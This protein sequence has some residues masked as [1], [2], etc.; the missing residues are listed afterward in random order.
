MRLEIL[1]HVCSILATLSLLQDK[2][3]ANPPLSHDQRWGNEV[4]GEGDGNDDAHTLSGHNQMEYKRRLLQYVFKTPEPSSEQLTIN[5]TT[6]EIP[7]VMTKIY[8]LLAE[9]EY[10]TEISSVDVD[11]IR[12][13]PDDVGELCSN[14]TVVIVGH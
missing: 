9:R 2:V 1:A 8:D 14:K 11:L 12:G 6:Q 7:Y 3:F 13:I 5:R 10:G 4:T